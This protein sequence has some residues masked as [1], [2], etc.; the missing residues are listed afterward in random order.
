MPILDWIS[1]DPSTQEPGLWGWLGIPQPK[2]G[3]VTKAHGGLL[4]IDE[5]GELHNIQLNK[6][7]FKIE[8]CF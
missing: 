7:K 1:S 5:I 8:K 3:A 4:F 2:P 6:L